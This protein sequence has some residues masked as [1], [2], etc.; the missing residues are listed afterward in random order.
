MSPSDDLSRAIVLY[1]GYGLLAY[2]R[3]KPAQYIKVGNV[4]FYA[5]INVDKATGRVNGVRT[6]YPAFPPG[7]G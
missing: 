6:V 5:P 1:V 2:P 3:E 7:G 4:W